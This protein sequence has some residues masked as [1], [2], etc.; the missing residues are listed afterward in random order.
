MKRNEEKRGS[1][2]QKGGWRRIAETEGR[3]GKRDNG[4]GVGSTREKKEWKRREEGS[5][6]GGHKMDKERAG[7]RDQEGR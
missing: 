1:G 5:D 2:K 6:G 4:R 3:R 7:K